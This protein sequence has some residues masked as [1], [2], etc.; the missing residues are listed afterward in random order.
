MTIDTV[1][2]AGLWDPHFN[3]ENKL[4]TISIEQS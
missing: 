2:L 4:Y 1:I 3:N